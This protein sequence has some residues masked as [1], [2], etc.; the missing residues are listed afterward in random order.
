M[1]FVKHQTGP[2]H[3]TDL[4]LEH[5][6]ICKNVYNR[7]KTAKMEHKVN[8]IVCGYQGYPVIQMS[9]LANPPINQLTSSILFS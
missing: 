1:T 2:H 9:I 3:F 7:K 5:K 8:C 6:F 4:P